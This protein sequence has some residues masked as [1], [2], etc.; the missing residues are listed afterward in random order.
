MFIKMSCNLQALHLVLKILLNVINLKTQ[1]HDLASYTDGILGSFY[2]SAMGKLT[3]FDNLT[4][5]SFTRCSNSSHGRERKR[6]RSAFSGINPVLR[7][8]FFGLRAH[9]FS[10]LSTVTSNCNRGQHMLGGLLHKV[11]GLHRNFS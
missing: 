4:M 8:S 5:P 6:R 1:K 11:T 2:S 9:G 10:V 3:P 7:F